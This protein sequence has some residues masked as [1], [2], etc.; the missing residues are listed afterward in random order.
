MRNSYH[1]SMV[2]CLIAVTACGRRDV[3]ASDTT[4]AAIR[5]TEAQLGGPVLLR[6]GGPASREERLMVDRLL[7]RVPEGHARDHVKATLDGRGGIAL[8]INF[9]GDPAS[10]ALAD[11]IFALRRT[12]ASDSRG[13]RKTVQ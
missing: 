12:R 2:L 13:A 11:S 3:T 7:A 6:Y 1:A 4:D 9:V 8:G 5:A 10:T